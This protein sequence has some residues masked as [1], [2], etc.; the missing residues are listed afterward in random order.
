[1]RGH[2]PTLGL[3]RPLR[4]AR[5]L[6]VGSGRIFARRRNANNATCRS[7]LSLLTRPTQGTLY[8]RF[9]HSALLS[10]ASIKG[11]IKALLLSAYRPAQT[12]TTPLCLRLFHITEFL[13]QHK[14][15]MA[16]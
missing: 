1:V 10:F 4:D 3:H 14:P 5:M 9:I 12:I 13:T 16:K 6:P 15:T 2:R 7:K 11:H 8:S